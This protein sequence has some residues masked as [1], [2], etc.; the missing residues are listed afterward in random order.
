MKCNLFIQEKLIFNADGLFKILYQGGMN[1][2][3]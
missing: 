2:P 3:T 1:D